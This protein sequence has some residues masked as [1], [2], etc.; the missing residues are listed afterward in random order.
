VSLAQVAVDSESNEIK[1]LPQL[2]AFLDLHGALVAIDAMGCQKQIATKVADLG[3]DYVIRLRCGV[4][5]H[6]DRVEAVLRDREHRLGVLFHALEEDNADLEA[7]P[8][9]EQHAVSTT[10]P[11]SRPAVQSWWTVMMSLPGM[12]PT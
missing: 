10:R 4:A 7:L 3:G 8:R 11:S 5:R 6:A 9:P 2:L 1:A 12:P